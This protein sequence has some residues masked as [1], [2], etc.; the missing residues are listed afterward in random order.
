M[1]ILKYFIED[2]NKLIFLPSSDG[3]KWM[4]SHKPHFLTDKGG[5][6]IYFTPI[7]FKLAGQDVDAFEATLDAGI[8]HVSFNQNLPENTII[9]RVFTSGGINYHM[10]MPYAMEK[11]RYQ[12]V[13]T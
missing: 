7:K 8:L 11:P 1:R 4:D 6:G 3:L 5:Q 12:E 10:K 13:V 2:G 9:W